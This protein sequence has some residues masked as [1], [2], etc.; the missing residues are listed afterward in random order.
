M[1]C[2]YKQYERMQ[3]NKFIILNKFLLYDDLNSFYT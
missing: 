1:T 2:F 3:Y